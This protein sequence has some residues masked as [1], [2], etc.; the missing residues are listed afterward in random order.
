MF[1]VKYILFP[2]KCP[3]YYISL[4][5]VPPVRWYILFKHFIRETFLWILGNGGRLPDVYNGLN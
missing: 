4:I 2:Y 5:D 3:V 1:F